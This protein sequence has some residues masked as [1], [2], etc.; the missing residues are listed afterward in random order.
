MRRP[1]YIISPCAFSAV[2]A[3]ERAHPS[4]STRTANQSICYALTRIP[5]HTVSSTFRANTMQYHQLT[6]R[7]LI[8]E[9]SYQIYL[10][11]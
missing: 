2:F 11:M 9:S 5:R 10:A 8:Q 1:V 7:L 3:R 4:T 6:H